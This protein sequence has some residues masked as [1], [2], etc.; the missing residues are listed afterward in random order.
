MDQCPLNMSWH[1]FYINA[2][3]KKIKKLNR[4]NKNKEFVNEILNQQSEI[5]V[6][7]MCKTAK[8]SKYHCL[9]EQITPSRNWFSIESRENTR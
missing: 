2:Y 5:Q 3:V 1:D 7:E 4:W 9:L 8:Y 6:T